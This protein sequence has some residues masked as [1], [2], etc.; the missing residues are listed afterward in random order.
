MGDWRPVSDEPLEWMSTKK[1]LK[2]DRVIYN[3]FLYEAI[4]DI[5]NSGNDPDKF[6]NWKK[7]SDEPLEWSNTLVYYTG[8]L[9]VH[10]GVLYK[11]KKIL[12][13]K[14]TVQI[15]LIIGRLY[16]IGH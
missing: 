4:H 3:G 2:G 9:V 14:T 5:S 15:N 11:A 1:Y 13:I 16:Q 7:I 6:N 8:D 12:V 10:K